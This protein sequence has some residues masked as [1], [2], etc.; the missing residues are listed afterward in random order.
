MARA[1]VALVLG[2]VAL[3][4]SPARTQEVETGRAI[5]GSNQLFAMA[6]A[7]QR[8][9]QSELAQS[10]YR[11]LTHDPTL[12]IRNEA[13]FRLAMLLAHQSK[14]AESAMLLRQILNEQPRAQRV[15]LE[16]ARLL[17]LMGDDAGARR[18]LREAQADGLPNDVIRFVDRYSAA[19][20]ARKPFGASVDVSIAPD[21]NINRATHHDTLG[22]VF[23]DFVLDDDA[24]ETSGVGL[25]VR[26]QIF[27]RLRLS[28]DASLLARVSG[29]GDFYREAGFNDVAIGLSAGPELSLG[30]DR[31]AIEGGFSRQMFGGLL[32]SSS[33]TLGSSFL[34]PLDRVSQLRVNAAIGARTDGLN[35]LQD[36]MTY[37]VT[38]GYE[39]AL[40][41]TFGFGG[42]AEIDRQSL[43]DAGYSTTNVQASIYAYRELGAT[44]LVASASHSRLI[45]DERL[46]IYPERRKDRFSRFSLGVTFR[47]FAMSK[48]A[49]FARLTVERN[50]SSIDI[51]DYRRTRTELGLTRAF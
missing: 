35:R 48:F 6:E 11:A 27:G 38:L 4:A 44:T 33:I 36:G 5:V 15:R 47:Q 3:P 30:Q 32:A 22:T 2:L 51:F 17:D 43:R 19:L 31:L 49:P 24:K 18:L 42:S 50:A 21:S 40:S 41:A 12:E 37:S 45:A 9:G 16:L 29:S 10:Y 39:R 25:A 7:A 13:R 14:L 34:H 23:G 20:R 1:L 8:R 26:G 28:E 46:Y